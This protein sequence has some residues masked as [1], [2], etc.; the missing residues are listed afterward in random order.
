M[1]LMKAKLTALVS[2]CI[3]PN[4]EEAKARDRAFEA[5]RPDAMNTSKTYLA[6][7]L[8]TAHTMIPHT[9]ARDNQAAITAPR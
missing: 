2:C 4:V 8:S 9:M 1:A 7:K 3:R 6:V 5:E